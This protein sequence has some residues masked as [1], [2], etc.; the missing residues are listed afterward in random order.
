MKSTLISRDEEV[1]IAKELGADSLHYLPVGAI[2]KALG[3]PE[4]NLCRACITCEY[5]TET[6]RRLFQLSMA[7]NNESNSSSSRT[8]ELTGASNNL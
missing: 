1:A 3:K 6:G 5:P 8:Y 4:S 7:H 2:S